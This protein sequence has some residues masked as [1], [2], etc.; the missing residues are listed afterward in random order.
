MLVLSRQT[1][2]SIH[3]GED[4]VI[5]I[6]SCKGTHVRVGISAPQQLSVDRNEVYQRKR[7]LKANGPSPGQVGRA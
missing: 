4:I 7:Q 1:G 3:I 2:Q 5:T 6:V